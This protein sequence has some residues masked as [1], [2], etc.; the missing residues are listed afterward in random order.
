MALRRGR[1]ASLTGDEAM[2]RTSSTQSVTRTVDKG[3][4]GHEAGSRKGKVHELYDT[5]GSDEAWTL[6]QK[7]GLKQSTLRTWFHT[8]KHLPR[9]LQGRSRRRRRQRSE[10]SRG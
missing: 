3:Y 2:A 9:R 8:W 1:S 7:L 4:R 6:G 5:K 10:L